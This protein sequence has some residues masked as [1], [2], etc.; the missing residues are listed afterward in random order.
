MTPQNAASGGGHLEVVKLAAVQQLVA[1]YKREGS[2]VQKY[3]SEMLE[4]FSRMK[5]E[6]IQY[7]MVLNTIWPDLC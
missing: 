2:K 6:F 1:Q 4:K 7:T 5:E 3:L